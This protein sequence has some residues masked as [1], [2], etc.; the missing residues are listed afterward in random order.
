MGEQ[1]AGNTAVLDLNAAEG[2][3]LIAPLYPRCEIEEVRS[4]R[5]GLMN[6]NLQVRLVGQPR[7]LL[8]R[9]HQRGLD[10]AKKEM[11]ICRLVSGRVPV[12]QIL[13]F[14]EDNPVTGHPYSLID[15][16]E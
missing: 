1:W 5:G 14:S 8:L 9:L 4:A 13:Y 15:W 16:V 7:A 6:S 3:C 10:F 2:G 11:A 12:P